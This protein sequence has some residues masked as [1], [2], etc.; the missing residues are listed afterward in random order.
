MGRRVLVCGGAGYIGSHMCEQLAAHGME[1]VVFDNLAGGRREH[2]RWGELVVGDL[3]NPG[4]LQALFDSCRFDAVM[5]FAGKIV[6][7]ESVREPVYFTSTTSPACSICSTP[8]A[9]T[10]PHPSCSRRCR[11]IRRCASHADRRGSCL[12]TGHSLR[13][14]Q[15]RCRADAEPIPGRRTDCA[16]SRCATSTRPARRPAA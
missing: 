13:P 6:A 15:A 11:R 5:Q 4:E 2:V 9:R 12:R 7:S 14:Q 16:A 8:R 1:V 10:T 3:R